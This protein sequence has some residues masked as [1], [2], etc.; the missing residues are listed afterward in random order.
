MVDGS[1][2]Q[3]PSL[4]DPSQA[5]RKYVPSPKTDMIRAQNLKAGQWILADQTGGS[6][7]SNTNDPGA[8]MRQ[9][10]DRIRSG[11]TLG[12]TPDHAPEGRVH[13]LRVELRKK[14]LRS[15]FTPSYFHGERPAPAA[16]RTLAALLVGLEE[17]TLGA[18]VSVEPSP[19]SQP[20]GKDTRTVN[21]RIVVPVERL[22]IVEDA[23]GRHGRLRVVIAIWRTGAPVKDQPVEIREQFIDVP[24]PAPAVAFEVGRRE[25][26][27]EVPLSTKHPE[28]AVGV[29][30]ALSALATYRRMPIPSDTR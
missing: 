29:H 28:L 4:A 5:D 19:A 14:G 23:S 3:A 17:D 27:V 12:L 16:S 15:R 11:Y 2:L 8:G 1:G 26:I 22:S 21:V 10:G 13:N 7:V 24:L 9:L 18:E 20:Q 25:F 30:D 6:V